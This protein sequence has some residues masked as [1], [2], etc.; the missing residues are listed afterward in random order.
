LFKACKSLPD[1]S[2]LRVI[3]ILMVLLDT[4]VRLGELVHMRL[5]D[6]DIEQGRIKVFGKGAKERY[7]YLGNIPGHEGENTYCPKCRTTV[8]ARYGF[9]IRKNALQGGA[10]PTCRTPI[11]GRWA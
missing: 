11:P 1:A 7:V 4:G 3:A 2:C 5:P 8:I 9:D 10:C 6:L